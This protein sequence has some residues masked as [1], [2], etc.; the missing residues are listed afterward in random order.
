MRA[1]QKRYLLIIITFTHGSGMVMV[2]EDIQ[3]Y[4]KQN[5][6]KERLGCFQEYLT[7]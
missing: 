1:K 7:K 5:E 4:N 3:V 6:N 2:M